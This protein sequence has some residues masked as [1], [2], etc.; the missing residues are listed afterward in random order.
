[1]FDEIEKKL[2]QYFWAGSGAYS[3]ITA[4]QQE[5]KTTKYLLLMLGAYSVYKSFTINQNSAADLGAGNN[6]VPPGNVDSS[7]VNMF[8]SRLGTTLRTWGGYFNQPRCSAL[9]DLAYQTDNATFVTI[10]NKYYDT[11]KNTLREDIIKLNT[12]GCNFGE[13]PETFVIDR[14]NQLNV[15]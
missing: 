7:Y 4:L 13:V 10:C 14:M 15:V 2:E 6:T 3:I 5:K 9:T 11:Y 8:V 12:N 1:M